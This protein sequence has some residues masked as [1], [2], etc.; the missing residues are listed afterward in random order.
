MYEKPFFI[1]FMIHKVP[2]LRAFC[3]C[4]PN[5][6]GFKSRPEHHLKRRIHLG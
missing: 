3:E 2:I 6:H 4:V 1:V 5:S